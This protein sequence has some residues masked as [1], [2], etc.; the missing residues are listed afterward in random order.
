MMT[1]DDAIPRSC[2]PTPLTTAAP[3]GAMVNPMPMPASASPAAMK[4]VPRASD[5]AGPCRKLSKK[6]TA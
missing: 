4:P 6:A 3:I 2:S 5:G 1:S